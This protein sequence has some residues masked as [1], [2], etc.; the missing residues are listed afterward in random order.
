VFKK[1]YEAYAAKRFSSFPV[2][3]FSAF[4]NYMQLKRKSLMKIEVIRTLAK[5]H[6]I[7]PGKLSKTRLI[8]VIQSEEGNF[9]CY[10][11]AYDGACDQTNCFWR[12]DCFNSSKQGE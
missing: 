8:K 6:G 10:A 4:D 9:D 12:E 3:L 5:S 2:F 11:S 7:H 1:V